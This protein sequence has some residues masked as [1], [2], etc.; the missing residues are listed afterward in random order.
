MTIGAEAVV[1]EAVVVNNVSP[2]TLVAGVPAPLI[3]TMSERESAT[4]A[5][6]Q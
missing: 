6:S 5:P 4:E 2:H 1:A 3:R